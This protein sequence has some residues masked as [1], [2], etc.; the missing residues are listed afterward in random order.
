MLLIVALTTF[1]AQSTEN[2]NGQYVWQF[3]SEQPWPEGYNRNTGKPSN[4]MWSRDEYSD[5]FFQRINNALPESA[6]NEA[7][8]TDDEGSTIYLEQRAEVFVTFIHEGAGYKNAFGFFTFDSDDPPQ[9]PSEI[10]EIIVFPNLSYPHMAKGHRLSLGIHPAGTSIGFFIAANG[11]SYYS[12]VKSQKSPYYYSLQG[13]NPEQDPAL[14]QHA[15]LLYD[16]E[17][18]EVILGFEDLPRT[19]GDNDFNDAVFSIKA[20]PETAIRKDTLN[21]VPSVDDSDADGVADSQ[22]AF[23]DDY[24]RA[25]S[26]YFPS[27]N[28]YV[29]LAYEDNWPNMGDFD[30]NDL[31]VKEQLQTTYDASGLVSGFIINGY[32][33]ARGGITANGFALRLMNIPPTEIE[34]ANLY[35]DSQIYS[36]SP[37]SNQSDAVISMW[38]D[39]K[40]F[41]ETG[42][43][44]KCSHFNTNKACEYFEPVSFTFDVRF[45]NNRSSLQYSD[46]DFFIYRTNNRSLEIHLPG[47]A[48]TDWFNFARFGK[49]DDTSDAE[50]GR[51]FRTKDNLPWALQITDDWAYPREYIDVL[52]AYPDFENWVESSGQQNIDWYQTSERKTHFYLAE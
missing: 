47:F 43:A 33:T 35:I 3:L 18:E 51:Y 14:R 20:T 2:I 15:V 36:K 48:P 49:G 26:S 21:I 4:L 45:S 50:V 7:F 6:L 13:L 29:T 10:Q 11:F 42:Q 31:V 37:E 40:R 24:R 12:G 52:W 32:I 28:S 39:S 9:S 23:P 5:D 1:T 25:Y 22:D 17:V 46:F 27:Q 44:G 38:S 8:I 16:E 30:F 19:W 34:S 41:T